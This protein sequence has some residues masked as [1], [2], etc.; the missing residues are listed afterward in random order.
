MPGNS[1][2]SPL[3]G[4]VVGLGSDLIQGHLNR[5]IAREQNEY[6]LRM[7][8]MQ[9]AYNSPVAQVNRLL[10]AGLN[11]NMVYGHG[12][13]LTPASAPA[14]AQGYDL[15]FS[16]HI[17]DAAQ[18][19]QVGLVESQIEKN[20]AE[21]NRIKATTPDSTQFANKFR[22]ET[23]TAFAK[24][25]SAQ[26]K[27]DLDVFNQQQLLGSDAQL[28]SESI[29]ANLKAGIARGEKLNYDALQSQIAYQ[30]A[31]ATKQ[32]NIEMVSARYNKI[33]KETALL[34]KDVESKDEQIT[35]Q[36]W[37]NNIRKVTGMDPT[38]AK[39]EVGAV[40]QALTEFLQGVVPSFSVRGLGEKFKNGVKSIFE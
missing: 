16:A 23:E 2:L 5:K 11:P 37:A 12:N 22:Y 28:Y 18:L 33:I 34:I 24:S 26:A 21:A 14:S 1:N 36:K 40:L 39:G 27:A 7:W 13:A 9:N 38:V 19:M 30:I 32:T 20:K 31:Y 15:P 35:Y 4:G 10:S 29:T 25:L 6:N 3:I 17:S 8:K